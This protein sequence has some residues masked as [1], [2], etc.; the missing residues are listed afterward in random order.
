MQQEVASVS[1]ER[2]M[3]DPGVERIEEYQYL[4]REAT[5]N[6]RYFYFSVLGFMLCLGFAFEEGSIGGWPW[7]LGAM[8]FLF[9]SLWSL[10]EARYF[11]LRIM[12]H[13]LPHDIRKDLS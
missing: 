5:K 6:M 1:E 2:S 11:D 7:L 12:L 10:I 13:V 9:G 3:S 4:R 8:L